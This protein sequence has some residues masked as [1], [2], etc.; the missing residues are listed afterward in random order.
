M[1]DAMPERDP[2]LDKLYHDRLETYQLFVRG[3]TL[4][5]AHVLVILLLM[6][7]FLY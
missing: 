5:V 1:Q 4:F 7:I 2:M 6:M 3:V